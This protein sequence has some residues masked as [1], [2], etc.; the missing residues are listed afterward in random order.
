MY[1]GTEL[2]KQKLLSKQQGF[3]Y[4]QDKLLGTIATVKPQIWLYAEN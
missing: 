2:Q 4:E 1:L 3:V